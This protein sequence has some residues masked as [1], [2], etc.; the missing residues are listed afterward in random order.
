MYVFKRYMAQVHA[1]VTYVPYLSFD[2]SINLLEFWL[3]W[4]RELH[5]SKL[6]LLF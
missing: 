6:N 5:K 2:L 4:F 1:Q 3:K